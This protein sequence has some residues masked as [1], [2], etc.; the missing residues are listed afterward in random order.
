MPWKEKGKNQHYSFERSAVS[1][2][3]T[4]ESRDQTP[5]KSLQR[6]ICQ[7]LATC[8]MFNKSIFDRNWM[9]LV[10]MS[11]AENPIQSNQ[12][13]IIGALKSWLHLAAF[14]NSEG[15]ATPGLPHSFSMLGHYLP[16][17]QNNK[18][19]HMYTPP[20]HRMSTSLRSLLWSAR[21]KMN[22]RNIESHLWNFSREKDL[23]MSK[24]QNWLF[25]PIRT[26]GRSPTWDATT[27]TSFLTC[28]KG[29]IGSAHQK[30]TKLCHFAS[31]PP[32]GGG[33]AKWQGFV[34]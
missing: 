31:P 20:A 26:Q 32:K 34:R 3:A 19:H 16:N 4:K 27:T 5:L 30:D 11:Q 6:K 18:K 25:E 8:K 14:Q 22:N 2:S 28:R 24:K 1:A 29:W 7:W 12:E 9:K 23:S 17:F 33:G 21:I 15:H 13:E 10:R